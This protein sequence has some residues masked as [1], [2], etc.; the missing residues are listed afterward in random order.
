MT[1]IVSV[2]LA[3]SVRGSGAVGGGALGLRIVSRLST[4]GASH[5]RRLLK[6]CCMGSAI[7][8]GTVPGTG[9]SA[10]RAVIFSPWSAVL[11]AREDRDLRCSTQQ[12]AVRLTA[13]ASVQ[14][15]PS[16]RKGSASAVSALRIP[17]PGRGYRVPVVRGAVAVS[18]VSG[19]VAAGGSRRHDPQC[20]GPVR[21][22]G[23]RRSHRR[24]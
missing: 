6:S 10:T 3:D 17:Y 16:E 22:T 24:I 23:S 19:E 13:P 4:F 21:G 15:L 5:S 14:S 12:A 2:T 9:R 1:A 8:T 18:T 11:R 7:P 20:P